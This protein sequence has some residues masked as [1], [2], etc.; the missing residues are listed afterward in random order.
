MCFD[1]CFLEM[2]K[3]RAT[4]SCKAARWWKTRD[5]YLHK[6]ESETDK[7]LSGDVQRSSG[8]KSI[9]CRRF[10]LK[11]MSGRR[12][13]RQMWVEYVHSYMISQF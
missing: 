5:E 10:Y 6:L 9:E 12:R 4:N 1:T 2:G 11:S 8:P 7:S 13:K 3:A